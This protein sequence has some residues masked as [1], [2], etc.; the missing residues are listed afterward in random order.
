MLQ[1]ARQQ[2]DSLWNHT[3]KPEFATALIQPGSRVS[4]NLAAGEGRL[5]ILNQPDVEHVF[6]AA[7]PDLPGQRRSSKQSSETTEVRRRTLALFWTC[8]REPIK[9][10][11]I[12]LTETTQHRQRD[13]IQEFR[14]RLF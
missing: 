14:C 1:R 11:N 6:G 13:R 5:L 2:T 3:A 4:L 12:V 8:R 7:A 10:V 9:V